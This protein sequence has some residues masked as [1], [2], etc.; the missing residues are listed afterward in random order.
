L[1]GALSSNVFRYALE[2][3]AGRYRCIPPYIS[4]DA[5]WCF[6][7]FFGDSGGDGFIVDGEFAGQ[8]FLC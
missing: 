1:V 8:S 7:P 3:S 2:I 5:S 6:N 4:V